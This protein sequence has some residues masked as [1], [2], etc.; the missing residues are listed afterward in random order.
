MTKQQVRS[1]GIKMGG[2]FLAAILTGI[3][4]GLLLRLLMKI[5]AIAYPEMARGFTWL[6]TLSL[7]NTGLVFCLSASL[8]FIILEFILPKWRLSKGLLFGCF[9]LI[10]YGTPFFL[11][12]PDND[13]FGP[14]APLGI[15]LFCALFIC[16]GILMAYFTDRI[17]TWV[18]VKEER[19]SKL[20]FAAFVVFILPAVVMFGGV[21]VELFT[22]TIPAINANN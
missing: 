14:Q 15:G 20:L 3:V 17:R 19:R 6:G 22:E 7:I 11:S 13:L 10:V 2:S 5:I 12:N 16:G 8:I 9:M 18:R 21:L 4:S 1:F